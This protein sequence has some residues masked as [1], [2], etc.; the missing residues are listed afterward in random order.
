MLSKFDHIIGNEEVKSHLV[1]MIEHRAVHSSL[2][3]AGPEGIGKSLFA[4]AFAK[5]LIGTDA[6]AHPDIRIFRPEGKIGMHSIDSMRKFSE[7]VYLQPYQAA[8]KV[9]IIHDADRML[10]YSANALLK[11]FEEPAPQSIIIL[12]SSNPEAHLPT[13]LSRCRTIRFHAIATDQISLLIQQKLGKTEKEANLIAKIARGSVGNAFRWIEKGGDHLREKVLNILAK[14][15]LA[16]YSQ[17][18]EAADDI[19]QQIELAKQHL[20]ESTRENIL[21]QYPDGLPAIQQQAIDK[22]ID[23]ILAMQQ[24]QEAHTVFDIIL[25]WY[26]DMHL[27]RVNGNTNFL[28]HP[29]FSQQ[30]E[31]ALKHGDVLPLEKVQKAISLT[32]LSIERSTPLNNCLENLFLHLDLL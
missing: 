10:T 27:L 21:K 9:F 8:W 3:F 14:G 12:L 11:T 31:Q 30:I 1:R 22:E 32:Q 7:E 13:V 23:G 19:A 6:G 20:E 18:I 16:N 4:E 5:L 17:L 28:F 25:S 26:R 24:A 2:L 15:K 29:D